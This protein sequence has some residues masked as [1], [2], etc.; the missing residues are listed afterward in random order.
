MR[1]FGSQGP[2]P[3]PFSL[4]DSDAGNRVERAL[5]ASGPQTYLRLYQAAERLDMGPGNWRRTVDK[6]VERATKDTASSDWYRAVLEGQV[7]YVRSIIARATINGV[8]LALTGAG[9]AIAAV[10]YER[11]LKP[12]ELAACELPIRE[13]LGASILAEARAWRDSQA[14]YYSRLGRISAASPGTA[15]P[16]PGPPRRPAHRRPAQGWRCDAGPRRTPPSRRGAGSTARC[17]Q[18]PV[19][20]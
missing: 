2:A 11:W 15:S 19:R 7:N 5:R 9:A 18:D 17:H 20:P 13:V 12:E 10:A 4:R 3:A 8:E 14:P 1:F 16:A 6:A